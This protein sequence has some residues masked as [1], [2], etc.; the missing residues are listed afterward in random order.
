LPSFP[1]RATY[2]LIGVNIVVFVIDMVTGNLIKAYGA[3]VPQFVI[4]YGQW[5]RIL[6]SGFLHAN[7]THL[8]FNLYAF[9]GLGRLMERF[10]N[11][12]R[13]SIIYLF[14]LLGSGVL[15]TLFSQF[16][17]LTL[18]A[19]GA[20]MGVLGG[21]LVFYWKYRDLLVKG[22]SYLSELGRMAIINIGIGLL[23]GISW[24]GHLGGFLA[25]AV[26]GLAM[27]PRYTNPDWMTG[28][29]NLKPLDQQSWL[30]SVALVVG[31]GALLILAFS[32]RG[33]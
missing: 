10:F 6:T 21:L 17:T 9:Y 16:S 3:L 5:W 13:L 30:I 4:S 27:L 33:R 11:T 2:I 7:I 14:A 24:W 26:A 12:R 22:R 19:S 28:Q 20:I 1:T 32:T 29:L 25:G 8:A 15:V 23:P 31:E 18:G